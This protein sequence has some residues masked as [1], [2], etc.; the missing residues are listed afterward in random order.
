MSKQYR[1][2]KQVSTLIVMG[3]VVLFLLAMCS[4]CSTV[5]PVA[6]KFPN[7]PRLGVGN[8]PQLQTVKDDVKLSELT[9]TVT[10]NYSTYYE[11]AV[12]VDQWNEWY[13]IQK[14]I[15]ENVK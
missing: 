14:R 2:Q 5:V 13:G 9:S 12:R 3:I 1:E 7:A 4:G 11:C 8:C 10:M 6:A 15:F